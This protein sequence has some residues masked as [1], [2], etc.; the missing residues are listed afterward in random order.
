[1]I[2]LRLRVLRVNPIRG[3]IQAQS[4]RL[5]NR[6]PFSGFDFQPVFPCSARWPTGIAH[7]LRA[8]RSQ[9]HTLFPRWVI[10]L[11][12]S[13]LH[14]AGASCRRALQ[15]SRRGNSR[16]RGSPRAG[17]QSGH[18]CPPQGSRFIFRG[19]SDGD[20]R[21]QKSPG[22]REFRRP[23]RLRAHR[24]RMAPLCKTSVTLSTNNSCPED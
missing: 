24:R 20:R 15:E 21:Q 12:D 22:L 14:F 4:E 11:L 17:N 1:M 9:R 19:L 3:S 7:T 13:G 18:D 10:R 23:G 6:G 2:P 16:A 8:D 5:S